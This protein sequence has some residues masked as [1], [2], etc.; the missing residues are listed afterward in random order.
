MYFL[1]FVGVFASYLLVLHREK[2]RFPWAKYLSGLFIVLALVALVVWL[3]VTK[4]GF[5]LVPSWPFLV[6]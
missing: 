5:H 1:F 6:R 2:R 3:A 4:Y